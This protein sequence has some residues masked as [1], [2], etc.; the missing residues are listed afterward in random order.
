MGEC[1]VKKLRRFSILMASNVSSSICR[2]INSWDRQAYMTKLKDGKTN[3]FEPLPRVIS[4]NF[5]FANYGA[6]QGVD[7]DDGKSLL[8]Q[9]LTPIQLMAFVL[10]RL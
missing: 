9:D 6:D 5:I 1:M 4:G 10:C 3:S 8:V 2:P 7:N